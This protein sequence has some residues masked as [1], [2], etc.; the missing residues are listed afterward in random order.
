MA[1]SPGRGQQPVDHRRDPSGTSPGRHQQHAGTDPGNRLAAQGRQGKRQDD[2]RRPSRR[3]ARR[4]GRIDRA[5]PAVAPGAGRQQPAAGPRQEPARS[6][7]REDLAP[8]KGNPRPAGADQR[9]AP[10]AVGK[11]RRRAVQGRRPG[12]RHRQPAEP[13]ERQEPASLRLPPACHRP[14]Q[15]AHPAQPRDQAAT[16]QPDPVQPGPRGTDQRPARQPAAVAHPL[17]AETGAAQDQGRPE[18]GRRDRR[19]A[20]RP[21][22]TEPGTRQAGDPAAIPGRP[23]RPAAQR[24]GHAGTAQGSRHPVG[25]PFRVARTAQPRTQRAAQRSDHLAV[26]P[27]TVA[28]HQREP[29]HH[30][31][32]ADVLDS[33][34]PA[35]RPV[36]VQDDP[37]PAEEPAHRDP[38]GLRGA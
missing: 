5:E 23:A 28:F 24:A 1:E 19:P 29:A 32:R 31:R 11:D 26:E 8:G 2:Q 14:P 4:A 38:L 18:P 3:A 20:P 15:R 7:H 25:N 33:Q 13:G 10:R 30:P 12:G 16:G 35:A 21:V 27:E 37:D 9:E 6:A 22:R 36:L 34:Q 17:Q